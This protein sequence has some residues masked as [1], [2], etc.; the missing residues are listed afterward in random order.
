MS[1]IGGGKCPLS[2]T[3][4]GPRIPQARGN[5]D[6]AKSRGNMLPPRKGHPQT[7]DP[8]GRVQTKSVVGKCR[9]S[10]NPKGRRNQQSTRRLAQNPM[11]IYP[12]RGKGPRKLCQVGGSAGR[13]DIADIQEILRGLPAESVEQPQPNRSRYRRPAGRKRRRKLVLG[14][15]IRRAE[16]L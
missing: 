8:S 2:E 14:R 12:Q 7:I 16:L 4:N 3:R 11:E 6:W 13:L 15:R 5:Q 10:N 9:L 1:S